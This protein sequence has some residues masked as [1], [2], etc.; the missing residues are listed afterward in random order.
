MILDRVPHPIVLAPLGGGPSTPALAAAV[1]EAGGLGFLAAAYK[2]AEQA[3][4]DIRSTRSLTSKPFGVNVFVPWDVPVDDAGVARYAEELRS[5][6][7]RLGVSLGGPRG[8]DDDWAA[9]IEM[10]VAER[11]AVV[12]FTFGC[13]SRDIVER[14]QGV[15][16]EVWITV[17]EPD[18]ASISAGRGADV[19][20]AQGVEAGGHRGTFSDADGVGEVGLLPL[21]QLVS[22][23]GKPIVAAGGIGSGRAIDAALAAGAS[24]AQ[25]GTAFLRATEAGTSPAYREALRGR[26]P[27]ALT[28]AFSGRRA[29]GLVNRFMREH[30]GPSGYPQVHHLTAPLRA[31]AR[32]RGDADA[33][34]VWAGQA[35][36]LGRDATA[37]EIMR[38]LLGEMRA[39][40]R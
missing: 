15:G 36:G 2:T 37:A 25:L 1:C 22:G 32:Q 4:D 19:L 29:R 13:P 33:F 3:R 11:P 5:E 39:A 26:G 21:L 30:R 20:V 9:K 40:T 34:N 14:L 35:Y 23:I 31:A 16:I 12:S 7:A 28:R 24:A 18:E 8:G 17:T 6:A 38:T 10:L 27:T